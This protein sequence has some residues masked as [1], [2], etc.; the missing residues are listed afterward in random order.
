MRILSICNRCKEKSI[1]TTLEV[2]NLSSQN[3]SAY[4]T[5]DL[6]DKSLCAVLDTFP[7]LRAIEIHGSSITLTGDIPQKIGNSTQL[8][9][10]KLHHSNL[11]SSNTA[12]FSTIYEWL[13]NSLPYFPKSL[14]FII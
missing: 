9:V 13:E 11:F 1:C 8:K 2:L 4:D 12:N 6:T 14:E 10:L 5:Q 7:N 3:L